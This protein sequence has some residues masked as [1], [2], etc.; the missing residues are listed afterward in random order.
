MTRRPRSRAEDGPQQ[1]VGRSTPGPAANSRSSQP[2]ALG[3]LLS[4]VKAVTAAAGGIAIDAVAWRET[5]GHRI[6]L[7]TR[8]GRIRNGALTVY[9]SSSVWAQELSFLADD[10]VARLQGAGMKVRSLRFCVDR[11]GDNARSP[12]SS[13]PPRAR[14]VAP[15]P[16]GVRERLESV[17]DPE[18]RR[19]IAEA[20]S[21]S[22]GLQ[23]RRQGSTKRRKGRR[24]SK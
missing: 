1:D 20:A 4:G 12:S 14:P 3:D 7:H 2:T 6:A 22:L 16:A 11:T 21:Q 9:V 17:D 8:P 5:V 10:L 24:R 15:L 23:T 13:P 18:L 19:I